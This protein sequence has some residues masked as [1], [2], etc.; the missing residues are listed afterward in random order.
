MKQ[1]FS[2][3]SN[4]KGV[5][6]EQF[7]FLTGILYLAPADL[8]GYQVCPMAIIAACKTPCLNTAGMGGVFTSIQRSRIAKTRR[9]FEDREAFMADVVYS[10][11][12]LI[13]AARKRAV[14][15]KGRFTGRYYVPLVRLNGT[16]DI[17]WENVPVTIDGVTYRNLMAA[18]PSVQFYD[19]SK[20]V[21]RRNL[22]ANYDITF[23]YS[24]VPAFQKFVQ[25]ALDQKMRIAAV[26]RFERDI[27]KRFLGRKVIAGDDSDVRSIE[28]RRALVALYAKGKAVKDTSGFVVG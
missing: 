11:R 8:S 27:P 13:K 2:I 20:L 15:F 28:P 26:F 1:L 5:K 6:G 16:S 7:G 18:F 4:A 23:S 24:G 22:P 10:I 19:Y 14:R 3:S 25:K 9:F 12:K 17:R 21:N